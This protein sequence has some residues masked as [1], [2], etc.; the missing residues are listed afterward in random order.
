MFTRRKLFRT[1]AI[2][3]T[4]AP[5]IATAERVSK[6]DRIPPQVGDC[7]A[8]PSFENDG[9]VIKAS[10]V[11]AGQRPLT[12]F[13]RDPIAG[14]TRERS[15][16][17]QILLM[18]LPQSSLDE[19]TIA[20]SADGLLAY[21]GVC[22]HTACAVSEWNSASLHLICPCHSSEFDPKARAKVVNGPAPRPLP[23]LPI[24]VLEDVIY[25][26]GGFSAKVG[27]K[28]KKSF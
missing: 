22:T 23:S 18:R 25:I 4:A 8:Y 21:S 16:L 27:A 12:V 17:N 14:I 9:L 20:A 13:P 10:A 3:I 5:A 26:T 11:Q 19:A 24:E 15:R 6:P 1:A 28:K 2:A 7:L